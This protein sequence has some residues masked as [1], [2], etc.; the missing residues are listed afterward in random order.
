MTELSSPPESSQP[1]PSSTPP[2]AT[3]PSSTPPASAP[4]PATASE[5]AP[6]TKPAEAA[7]LLNQEAPKAPEGAPEKYEDF[8]A[9]EGFE[10]DKEALAEATPLFKELGLSQTQAQRLVDFYAKQSQQAAQAPFDL[11]KQTQDNWVS[12]IKADP[13]IGGKLDAVRTGVARMLDGLGNA[14]L[15]N[16]FRQAMDYTGAGNNPAFIRM[17]WALAQRLTEG[18]H[19]KGGAPSPYGQGSASGRPTA[20]SALYPNLPNAG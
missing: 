20:A 12:E 11:W 17:M 7:S 4:P 13:E 16:E 5:A 15:T 9:P 18:G 3:P 19:V 10:V 2:S 8:K 1:S 14:K 6:G